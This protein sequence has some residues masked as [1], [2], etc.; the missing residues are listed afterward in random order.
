MAPIL[1]AIG[2]FVF[3]ACLVMG[4]Y[5]AATRLPGLLVERKVEARMADVAKHLTPEPGL[6]FDLV[7]RSKDGAMPAID[8]AFAETGA[9]TWVS[10]LIEQAGSKTGVS[11][12]LLSSLALGTA[13][14]LTSAS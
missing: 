9:G 5:S 8:R 14:A 3:A 2:V 6:G 4:L 11:T 7:K 12:V 10:K 1:I 13:V